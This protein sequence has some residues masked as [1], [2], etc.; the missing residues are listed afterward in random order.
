MGM[1]AYVKSWCT[2]KTLIV[3]IILCFIPAIFMSKQA[4]KFK[5]NDELNKK[6]WAFHRWDVANWKMLRLAFDAFIFLA[7]IRFAIAWTL[8]FFFT[9][10]ILIV[11]IGQDK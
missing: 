10:W 6:Y 9:T 2:F 1:L 8:V 7:P 3:Y 11:M 5:G 4:K